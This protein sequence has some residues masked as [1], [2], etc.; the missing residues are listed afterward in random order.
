MLGKSMLRS[1]NLFGLYVVLHEKIKWHDGAD[2]TRLQL[3]ANGGIEYV[4]LCVGQI[5]NTM[6]NA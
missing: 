1:L 4:E 6:S 3:L 2:T 5:S